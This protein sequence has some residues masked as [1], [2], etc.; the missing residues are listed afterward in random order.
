M[1][2]NKP[3]ELAYDFFSKDKEAQAAVKEMI[4][5]G[6]P[7]S[8]I[9][10]W[11]EEY[12]SQIDTRTKVSIYKALMVPVEEATHWSDLAGYLMGDEMNVEY[13]Y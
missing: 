1:A 12:V 10:E 3:T 4:A 7:C 13:Y 2:M 6:K 5:S 8:V 9:A 11:L